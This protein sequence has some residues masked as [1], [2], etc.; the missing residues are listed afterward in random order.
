MSVK[1]QIKRATASAWTAA[2]PTL[3]AGE[4]GME[5]DTKKLKLGTGALWNS[6]DYYSETLTLN[7]VGDVTITSLQNGDFLRYSS[8]ASAWINDPVNLSTDTVGDYVQSLTAG[9]GVTLSNNSGEGATPTVAI[10]QAVGTSASV[11]F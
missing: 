3:A 11:T 9:T 2:N 7:S 4:W 5:L 1:I 8:S 10:G 6:T